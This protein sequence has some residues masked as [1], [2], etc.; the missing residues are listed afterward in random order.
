MVVEIEFALCSGG[1]IGTGRGTRTPKVLPPVDFESS[2]SIKGYIKQQFKTTI[3]IFTKTLQI[4]LYL[5]P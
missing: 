2:V 3:M 5:T 4:P 1:I